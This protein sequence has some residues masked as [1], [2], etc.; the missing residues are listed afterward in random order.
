MDY[1]TQD[2]QLYIYAQ[3]PIQV[4]WF[5]RDEWG[6]LLFAYISAV[7]L[8]GIVAFIAAIS[9]ATMTISWKRSKAR[10]FF[11]L[12]LYQFGLSEFELYPYSTTKQFDE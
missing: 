2:G 10:G 4:F 1:G 9:L 7:N 3:L 12:T 8:G 6:L 5:D 11:S